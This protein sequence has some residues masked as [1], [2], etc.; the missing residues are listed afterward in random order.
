[1][2]Q[3]TIRGVKD[4]LTSFPFCGRVPRIVWSDFGGCETYAVK[5]PECGCRLRGVK[6]IST[7]LKLWE[8]RAMKGG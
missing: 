8:K 6:K 2:K 3:I 4:V 7:A 1:M 5:C